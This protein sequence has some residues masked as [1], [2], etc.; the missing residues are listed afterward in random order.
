MQQIQPTTTS[1]RIVL[2]DVIRGFAVFGILLSNILIFSGFLSTPFSQL[3]EYSSASLNHILFYL[4]NAFVAG[5]F[6]PIFCI[7]FGFGF[8]MQ[9]DKYNKSDKSFVTYYSLRLIILLVIGFMHQI[10]WPGDIVTRY[11]LIGFLFLLFRNTTYK[12][13]L[14]LAITFFALFLLFG[15]YF[16]YFPAAVD[17]ASKHTAYMTFPG[18]DNLEL[19]QK[20]RTEGLSGIYFFYVPFYKFYWAFERLVVNTNN[21]I[22]LFFLG[23]YLYKSDFFNKQALKARNLILFFVI[24]AIGLYLRYYV[25]YPLRI[26]DTVFLALF[27]MSALAMIYKKAWGR[28]LLQFLVPVGKMALTCYILQTILCITVFYGI[29]MGLFAQLP[30][31]QIYYIAFAMLA[32]QAIFCKLWLNYFQFG[33]VEWLWRTLSY[34]KNFSLKNRI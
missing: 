23:G 2:L 12:Q 21:L 3:S 27:Y 9:V 5:K 8:Y 22:G 30:L 15:F 11:A 19:I 13:D 34:K 1:E 10:I 20:L 4:S 29:G 31:Y 28:K 25:A 33:P 14:Y 7:L 16:T 24:G 26:F 32:F 17:G 18:I 6:Y